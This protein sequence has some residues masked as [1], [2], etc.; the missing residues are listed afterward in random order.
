MV[1]PTSESQTDSNFPPSQSCLQKLENK[2][3]QLDLITDYKKFTDSVE[4]QLASGTLEPIICPNSI[5]RCGLCAT[6]SSDAE[7]F[8]SLINQ[9]C[10]WC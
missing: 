7:T 3:G 8:K 5:C 9:S 2:E 10:Y 1:F 4:K 6:K